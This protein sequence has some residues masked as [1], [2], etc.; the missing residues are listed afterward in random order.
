MIAVKRKAC[1][2]RTRFLWP[3]PGVSDSAGRCHFAVVHHLMGQ[4]LPLSEAMDVLN[5]GRMCVLT[6]PG[7][8]GNA[9]ACSEKT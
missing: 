3:K 4:R 2:K 5:H 8:H 9:A 6:W 1:E 7:L